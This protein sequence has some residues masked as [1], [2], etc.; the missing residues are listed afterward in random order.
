[1][2]KDSY[3]SV[4]AEGHTESDDEKE[5]WWNHWNPWSRIEMEEG[6]GKQQ[7]YLEMVPILM[8]YYAM[9]GDML[10]IYVFIPN[11][12]MIVNIYWFRE[13]LCYINIKID[14]S[15]RNVLAFFVNS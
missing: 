15:V 4:E 8:A 5:D 1:M 13:G 3:L 7:I 2:F 10:I 11:N 6:A 9:E 12:I 14:T